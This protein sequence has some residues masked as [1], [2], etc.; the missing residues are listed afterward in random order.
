MNLEETVKKIEENCVWSAVIKDLKESESPI[1]YIKSINVAMESYLKSGEMWNRENHMS[2]FVSMKENT[3]RFVMLTG[4]PSTGKSM[5]IKT[6]LKNLTGEVGVVVDGRSSCS[7]L[8][9]QLIAKLRSVPDFKVSKDFQDSIK[10]GFQKL[11][12]FFTKLFSNGNNTPMISFFLDTLEEFR[13]AEMTNNKTD[14]NLVEIV[15]AVRAVGIKLSFLFID[16]ANLIFTS[17][18]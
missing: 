12:P 10:G 6:I 5:L 4:G 2:Q 9:M 17:G 11:M 7:A 18:I 3:H 1:A 15:Q 14:D 13:K 8:D 16:E